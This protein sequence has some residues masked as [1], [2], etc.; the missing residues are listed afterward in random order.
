MTTAIDTL[1]FDFDGTLAD[2]SKTIVTTITET[3]RDSN[4]PILTEKKVKALIG[5]SL[6][7]MFVKATGIADEER[8]DALCRLYREKFGDIANHTISLFPG[9]KATLEELTEAGYHIG[10]ATSRSHA[11]LDYLCEKLGIKHLIKTAY[12]EDDVINKKPA[13]DMV[14]AAMKCLGVEPTTTMVIGDTT[15]DIEMGRA[16]GCKTCAV[17]YGNHDERQLEG[18]MPDYIIDSLPTLI[19]ILAE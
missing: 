2:T 4:L 13:P 9:V 14:V 5:L 7:D 19:A 3:L 10:I 8:I 16:A 1:I 15:F 11:S 18:A 12:A 6:H 17:T